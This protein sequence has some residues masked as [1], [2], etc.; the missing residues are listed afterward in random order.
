M[1]AALRKPSVAAWAVNQLVRT[2]QAAVDELFTAGDGLRDAQE[3]VLAGR[4]DGR[5]LRSGAERERAAVDEL[6]DK[7]RGLLSS[8]GHELSQMTL[9]RVAETLHAAALDDDARG[10]VSR[11]RLERELRHV[12]LGI[13]LGSAS[14]PPPAA[15]RSAPKGKA[16]PRA[17]GGRDQKP[18]RDQPAK[19]EQTA[20]RDQSAKRDQARQREQAAAREQARQ[21]E[22][23]R[24]RA[25]AAE[26]SARRE[27]DRA[28]RAVRSAQERHDRAVEAVRQAE[29]QLADARGDAEA[30]LSAHCQATQELD[31]LSPS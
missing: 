13:G 6:S 9:D 19:R 23:A 27:L 16:G 3:G 8:A 26:R 28:E 11:G 18:G 7:A 4:A 14:G 24:K 17:K 1:V 30:A 25:R 21:V 31:A 20:E 22:Q 2:Q 15:K 29:E 5:A 12:G 10:S